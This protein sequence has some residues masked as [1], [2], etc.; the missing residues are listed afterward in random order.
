M[1]ESTAAD[2]VEVAAGTAERQVVIAVSWQPGLTARDA[3]ARS[4]IR[5]VL[6]ELTDLSVVLGR[7]G[8]AIDE[9]TVLTPGDRVELCRPLPKD[10]REMRRELLAAAAAKGGGKAPAD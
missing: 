9:Q 7:F 10:P 4:A 1:A 8:E 3:I 5:D 6:P 2:V